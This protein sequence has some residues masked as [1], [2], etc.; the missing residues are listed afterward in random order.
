MATRGLDSQSGGKIDG[1]YISII[2]LS[3]NHVG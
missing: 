2:A 3:E 1:R